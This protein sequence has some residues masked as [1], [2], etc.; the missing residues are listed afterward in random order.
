MNYDI[1]S[2]RTAR[3]DSKIAKKKAGHR[4]DSRSVFLA[5]RLIGRRADALKAKKGG[6]NRPA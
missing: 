1:E 4:V 3:R 2:N 5:E 6:A